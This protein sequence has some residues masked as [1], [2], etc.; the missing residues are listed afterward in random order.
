VIKYKDVMYAF[1]AD[2]YVLVM[3]GGEIS[4]PRAQIKLSSE[5]LETLMNIFDDYGI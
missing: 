5:D 3:D 4:T 1:S 2:G